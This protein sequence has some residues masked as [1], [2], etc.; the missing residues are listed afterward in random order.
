MKS[1]RVAKS[2]EP[3]DANKEEK[4]APGRPKSVKSEKSAKDGTPARKK[5][6]TETPAKEKKLAKSPAKSLGKKSAKSAEGTPVKKRRM[7]KSTDKMATP[8]RKK[9]IMMPEQ[10]PVNPNKILK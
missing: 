7:S 6:K 5:A 4:K 10:S 2:A 3:K 9:K 8:G 1:K